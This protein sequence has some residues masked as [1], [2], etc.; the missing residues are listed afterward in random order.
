VCDVGWRRSGRGRGPR[1][2]TRATTSG[3]RPPCPVLRHVS[4]RHL[5]GEDAADDQTKAGAD[6]GAGAVGGHGPGLGRGL[7]RSSRTPAP[8]SS[9]PMPP[10]CTISLL[11]VCISA[12][13]PAESGFYR[14]FMT[15]V[16]DG[17]RE[18]ALLAQVPSG[19]LIGGDWRPATGDRVLEVED[20]ATGISVARVADAPRRMRGRRSMPPWSRSRAGP[21]PRRGSAGRSCVGRSS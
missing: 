4:P 12:L 15:A 6:P 16:H 21:R 20:P 18:A 11:S 1:R 2:A 14:G 9:V 5:V 17:A 8:T 13:L 7:R 19:L 10:I 3:A